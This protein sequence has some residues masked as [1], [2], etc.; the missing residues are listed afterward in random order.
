MGF[1]K[2]AA[3]ERARLC[4]LLS[5]LG[6]GAPT[7]CEGWTTHDLAAHLVS[8]ESQLR[9]LP[10]LLLGG[11]P[12]AYTERL[13]RAV[14]DRDHQRLVA[15]LRS[16]PPRW[17]YGWPGARGSLHLH[18]LFPH[19]E[20]VRRADGRNARSDERLDRE[21]WKVLRV[22]GPALVRRGRTGDLRIHAVGPNGTELTMGRGGN[23]LA[24]RGPPGEIYLY[25]LG[26]TDHAAVAIDGSASA[27]ASLEAA[28]LRF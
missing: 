26:R 6:P 28:D 23:T 20:D 21:L 25:L 2:V 16:G 12:G 10:G 13:R 1:A 22:L 15:A 27:L 7:L 4:E 14:A 24:M 11:T 9:A 17:P 8:R 3:R 19:H 18:E 5:T